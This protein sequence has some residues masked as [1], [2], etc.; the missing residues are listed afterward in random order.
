MIARVW[1]GITSIG[2]ADQYLKYLNQNVV[3]GYQ[4]VAGN[5]GVFIFREIQGELAHFLLLSIWSSC[6]DLAAFPDPDQ[7]LARQ[8]PEAQKFLVA[9]ESVVTHYEVLQFIL[10]GDNSSLRPNP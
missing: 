9:S 4:A 10:P 5:Q 8:A 6:D 7:E 1:R 2:K 3:P